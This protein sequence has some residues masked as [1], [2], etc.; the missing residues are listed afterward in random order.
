MKPILLIIALAVSAT[1]QGIQPQYPVGADMT[2]E[3]FEL[4]FCYAQHWSTSKS[5]QY[6]ISIHFI[7]RWTDD[8]KVEFGERCMKFVRAGSA[9][10][11]PTV[12]AADATTATAATAATLPIALG[13]TSALLLASRPSPSWRIRAWINGLPSVEASK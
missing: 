6:G 5:K 11:S 10:A 3:Q 13:T 2:F 4:N 9:M 8:Q 7:G 1:A 12:L